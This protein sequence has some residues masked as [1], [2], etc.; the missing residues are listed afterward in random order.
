MADILSHFKKKYEA[1]IT[2]SRKRYARL[3]RVNYNDWTSS[4]AIA[5]I[6][7]EVEQGVEIT[8]PRE[9]FHQLIENDYYIE[10]SQRDIDYNQKIVDMLRADERV[11]MDNESVQLAYK[12]YLM[13]L[14]LARR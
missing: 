11:R 10:Q 2:E 7:H 14:E 8:M 9:Q 12:K 5:Y 1:E 4:T 6:S 13:L 3:P